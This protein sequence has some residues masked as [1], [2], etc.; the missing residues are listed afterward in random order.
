[1]DVFVHSARHWIGAYYLQL[2]GVDALVFTAGI[3]ENSVEL[4][5]AIC[6]DLDQLGIILD[7]A[8]NAQSRAREASSARRNRASKSLSFRPM[9]NWLSP[10]RCAGFCNRIKTNHQINL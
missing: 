7:P 8:L 10:A 6:R 1:L 3:G 9:K 5:A 2:N 4:R